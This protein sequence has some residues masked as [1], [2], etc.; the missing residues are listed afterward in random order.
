MTKAQEAERA[1][2]ELLRATVIDTK[3]QSNKVGGK[4]E[5]SVVIYEDPSEMEL[6]V[7]IE[8]GVVD[9]ES[10]DCKCFREKTIVKDPPMGPAWRDMALPVYEWGEEQSSSAGDHV[11]AVLWVR[12]RVYDAQDA[13]TEAEKIEL[14]KEVWDGNMKSLAKKSK[15]LKVY[16]TV[17]IVVALP[18]LFLHTLMGGL[19]RS[20]R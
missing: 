13:E 5:R 18:L 4:D 12:R 17:S 7:V 9:D 10:F 15:A 19:P 20:M 1:R 16:E 6:R 3:L 8:R 11:V 2:A 14:M